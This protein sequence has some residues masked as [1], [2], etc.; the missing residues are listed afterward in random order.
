MTGVR[1]T[2]RVP[3]PDPRRVSLCE[4]APEYGPRVLFFSG[5]TALRGASRELIRY[6][7]NS[8]HLITPFDSGGSSAVL[9]R[10][11]DMLAVGDMRNRLMALADQTVQG[12][13]DVYRLFAF[14]FPKDGEQ[15]ELVRW[16]DRMVGGD[17]PMVA[18]I[19]DPLRKLIRNHLRFFREEMPADFDLRGANIGNLILVGGFLNQGRHIDPVLFLFARL[20]KARGVVRPVS[21]ADLQLAAE[22]EDGRVVVGQHRL[23]GKQVE[24]LTSPIRRLYLAR[25]AA[26]PTPVEQPIRDKVA[27]LIGQADVVIYP[28]GSFYSSVLANLLCRGVGRAV[29]AL[30]VPKVYVPN[31]GHDPEQ[32]GMTLPAAVEV[33]RS[34]LAADD[35]GAIRIRDV[36]QYVLVDLERGGQHAVELDEVRAMGVEVVDVPLI[37]DASAP[38]IDPAQLAKVLVSMA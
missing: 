2:R 24:P 1:L 36:L 22:L 32:V 19:G 37:T 12:Q 10:A 23:T 38:L 30:D 26:D 9:R 3:L 8:I 20:V 33:L 18:A 28:V 27:T 16:L 17:D 15:A 4:R 29:A 35:P 25:S 21:S 14:R 7:H 5:G 34:T 11:F 6:T 13:P 31:T